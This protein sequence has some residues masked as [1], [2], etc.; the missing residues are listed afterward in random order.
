MGDFMHF[1]YLAYEANLAGDLQREI[2]CLQQ[3]LEYPDGEFYVRCIMQLCNNLIKTNC[4][5]RCLTY[6]K[7]AFGYSVMHGELISLQTIELMKLMI[8]CLRKMGLR[9]EELITNRNL[10]AACMHLFGPDNK[11]TMWAEHNFYCAQG[12]AGRN[13]D[14]RNGLHKLLQRVKLVLGEQDNLV[15]HIKLNIAQTYIATGDVGV[16]CHN[17]TVLLASLKETYGG[18]N[19]L[20]QI[21]KNILDQHSLL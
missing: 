2:H 1:Y 14:C 7:M 11:Q 15:S 10:V 16:G 6:A 5:Q 12:N 3:A 18:K 9:R 21:C 8:Q 4:Y 13:L 17:L 20:T 19:Q